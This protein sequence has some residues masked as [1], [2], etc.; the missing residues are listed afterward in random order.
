MKSVTLSLYTMSSYD[1]WWKYGFCHDITSFGSCY[2][3]IHNW[4]PT[5]MAYSTIYVKNINPKLFQF[6]G[7]KLYTF[8]LNQMLK[9][10][11]TLVQQFPLLNN[12][13]AKWM[14][15]SMD[16]S[17]TN[18]IVFNIL[19]DREKNSKMMQ[20]LTLHVYWLTLMLSKTLILW[21]ENLSEAYT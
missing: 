21:Q 7:F 6:F 17:N 16:G 15:A 13:N 14:H 10:L 20:L 12:Q 8:W 1:D 3:F 11:V 18:L 5:I 9:I 19:V 4:S 2:P